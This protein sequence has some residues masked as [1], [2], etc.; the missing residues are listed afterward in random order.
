MA[1]CKFF[2]HCFLQSLSPSYSRMRGPR[3]S[4]HDVML[5]I[6]KVGCGREVR[7]W[8]PDIV[9]SF[10]PSP[11]Y[12]GYNFMGSKPSCLV[13]GELVHSHTPPISLCPA[14]LS[15][16]PVTATGCQCLKPILAPARLV[17]S[18]C[19]PS[20]LWEPRDGGVSSTPLLI[21]CL[22]WVRKS[23]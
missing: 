16:F 2:Q 10:V 4:K 15:P 11:V 18:S 7:K 21:R 22:D 19:E 6:E 1:V 5:V 20:R 14:S 17:K 13:S 9:W 23:L 3:S 8:I 12:A